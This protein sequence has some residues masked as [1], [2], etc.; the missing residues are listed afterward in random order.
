MTAIILRDW[1]TSSPPEDRF[2]APE[3]R[4]NPVLGGKVYGHPDFP[5]GS[6]ILSS[7][8]AAADGR[9]VVTSSG[10]V[11][12]LEG[13]PSPE[14]IQFLADIGKTVDEENP[15]K[16]PTFLYGEKV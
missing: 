3:C 12:I 7:R 11:Y 8:I 2:R 13:A 10:R 5:D 16:F 4:G 15:L 6:A 14:W 9:K 1:C